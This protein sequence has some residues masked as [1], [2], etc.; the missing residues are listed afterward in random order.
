MSSHPQRGAAERSILGGDLGHHEGVPDGGILYLSLLVSCSDLLSS[1][2]EVSSPN[3]ST[4]RH[5]LFC[6]ETYFSSCFVMTVTE[7]KI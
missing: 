1:S 3:L 7:E 6:L 5:F 4:E 2:R